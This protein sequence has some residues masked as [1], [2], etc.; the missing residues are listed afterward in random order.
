MP[1][2]LLL[3][4]SSPMQS[5]GTDESRLDNR[6]TIYYPTKSA[7]IGMIAAAF[8]LKRDGSNAD[9]LG[10]DLNTLNSLRFGVRID[11][12]GTLINDY[13]ISKQH[14]MRDYGRH[15]KKSEESAILSNRYYLSDA[16]FLIALESDDYNIINKIHDALLN[17]YWPLYFGRKA[18]S[19]NDDMILNDGEHD[20][21]I[22]NYG[23]E[24]CFNTN[25]TPVLASNRE[26]VIIAVIDDDN[27]N[28]AIMDNP[29]SYDSSYR[30]Y[31]RR[32]VK[33]ISIRNANNDKQNDES[34]SKILKHDP[35]EWI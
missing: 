30:K 2:T 23:I 29:V 19:V 26:N 20:I 13:Q 16:V 3:K 27:G 34:Y 6:N 12:K 11:K 35:M 32:R 15:P 5:Y 4:A 17:P 21:S 22:R 24:E 25:N 8:G 31:N 1:T 14:I 28:I 7:I 18:C 9:I 33:Q 10:I